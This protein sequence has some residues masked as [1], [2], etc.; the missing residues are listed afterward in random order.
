[1]TYL[2]KLSMDPLS[3]SGETVFPPCIISSK[4]WVL[5]PLIS[6]PAW[7]VYPKDG[8]LD[9]VDLPIE[10]HHDTAIIFC[11]NIM[12]MEVGMGEKTVEQ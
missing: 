4:L 6:E 11:E 10:D 5:R 8:W 3:L 9:A 1:M 7:M 2:F 12:V